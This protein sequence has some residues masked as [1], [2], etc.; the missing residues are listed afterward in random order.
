M[1]GAGN[2]FLVADAR[3]DKTTWTAD[4]V[5][6]IISENPRQDNMPIEG[7]LL[8][9][10]CQGDV[11]VADFYNPDG[12]HGMMCGNGARCIVRFAC[13]HGLEHREAIK[14]TINGMVFYCS[15]SNDD[16]VSIRFPAPSAIRHYPI[17]TLEGIDVDVWYVNVGTDHVVIDGPINA[18]RPEVLRLRHHQEFPNGT[19]VNMVAVGSPTHLATFERGVESVTGACGTGALSCAVVA[20]KKDRATLNHTF[21]PPSGREL[22]VHLEVVD[23]EIVSMTL[24]GD[25][26][27]DN[28]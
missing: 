6:S 2:R 13:D 11:V 22:D 17:G 5:R 9:R 4:R 21:I 7:L 14:L 26:R 25:A 12:T 16:L 1:S 18:Q 8:L 27:Y 24:T 19:N 15:V 28:I 10:S 23:S 20:W 3:H